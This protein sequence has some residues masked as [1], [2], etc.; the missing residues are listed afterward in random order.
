MRWQV[1]HDD[2]SSSGPVALDTLQR[3]ASEGRITATCGLSYDGQTWVQA[4]S[5]PE[6]EMDWLVLV[7]SDSVIG[8]FAFAALEVLRASGDIPLDAHIFRR[9]TDP[10]AG[11]QGSQLVQRTVAAETHRRE[12]EAQ[13]QQLRANLEAKDLEFQ[14]ERQQLAAE[15]SRTKAEL[16]RRD[17]EISALKDSASQLRTVL[18]EHQSLE[19]RI[20]DGERE[21]TGLRTECD[22]VRRKLATAEEARDAARRD[23]LNANAELRAELAST[24]QQAQ[25]IRLQY[26]ARSRR[27]SE[28]AES[29][30]E[31]ATDVGLSELPAFDTETPTSTPAVPASST[32]TP[33]TPTPDT[34]PAPAAAP[35]RPEFQRRAA[36]PAPKPS[37]PRLAAETVPEPVVVAEV[38]PP[39]RPRHAIQSNA[40]HGAGLRMPHLATLE[41]QAQQELA[42]LK[43][44]KPDG[45]PFWNRRKPTS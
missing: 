7:S 30:R 41:A 36:A 18:E 43:A 25:A 32:P 13:L 11:S 10:A 31:L 34:K 37:S 40:P 26:A 27:F 33:I 9:Q 38:L 17:A 35:P 42:R 21:A 24:L 44:S 2:G 45:A 12:A 22:D 15:M 4:A 23:A 39:E 14:A 28:L 20:V 5:L 19:A 1:R 8:P 29:M 6:L 16:L 3:W